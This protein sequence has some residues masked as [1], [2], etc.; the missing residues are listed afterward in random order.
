MLKK[1]SAGFGRDGAKEEQSLLSRFE[2]L[3]NVI[4]WDLVSEDSQPRYPPLRQH[5]N[6]KEAVTSICSCSILSESISEIK[7][8]SARHLGRTVNTSDFLSTSAGI[9]SRVCLSALFCVLCVCM[10]QASMEHYS[11]LGRL[12]P[13]ICHLFSFATLTCFPCSIV[14]EPYPLNLNLLRQDGF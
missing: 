1:G 7:S 6:S 2:S 12:A 8:S 14:L 13:E 5:P 4:S 10:P 3:L 11:N 9:A